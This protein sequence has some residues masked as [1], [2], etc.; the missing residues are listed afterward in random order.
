MPH[1]TDMETGWELLSNLPKLIGKHRTKDVKL[2]SNLVML[3]ILH[4]AD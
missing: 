4:K 3:A 2:I 1:F